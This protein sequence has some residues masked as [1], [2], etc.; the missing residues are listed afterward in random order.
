[1][2]YL[3]FDPA[4]FNILGKIFHCIKRHPQQQGHKA[5]QLKIRPREEAGIREDH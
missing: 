1:M 5:Q 2:Q 3:I 4:K